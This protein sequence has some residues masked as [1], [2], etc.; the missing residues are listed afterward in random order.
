MLAHNRVAAQVGQEEA[1]GL[2]VQTEDLLPHP[3]RVARRVEAHRANKGE[4]VLVARRGGRRIGGAVGAVE[5][6]HEG[7][8][9]NQ[10]VDLEHWWHNDVRFRVVDVRPHPPPLSDE[11]DVLQLGHRAADK[12]G[13]LV[14]GHD[15]DVVAALA[16]VVV[17]ERLRDVVEHALEEDVA[18]VGHPVQAKLEVVEAEAQVAR[19]EKV[20]GGV[21]IEGAVGGV[22]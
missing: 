15:E 4:E 18:A 12:G 1:L 20:V 8:L 3:H 17:R 9:G 2:V 5:R 11:V 14:V 7:R 6:A 16:P 13:A 10:L 21:R 19:N 22:E